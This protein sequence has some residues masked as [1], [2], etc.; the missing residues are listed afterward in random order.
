MARDLRRERTTFIL[1]TK[2]RD[3]EKLCGGP[4]L[5]V[6]AWLC[7]HVRRTCR[8]FPELQSA[9]GTQKRATMELQ[10]DCGR[11]RAEIRLLAQGAA[12]KSCSICWGVCCCAAPLLNSV[13]S[14]FQWSAC[15]CQQCAGSLAAL[16]RRNCGA[17]LLN[18]TLHCCIHLL[19]PAQHSSRHR[20]TCQ[21]LRL[22][23]LHACGDEAVG[24]AQSLRSNGCSAKLLRSA[25]AVVLCVELNTFEKQ[26]ADSSQVGRRH[27]QCCRAAESAVSHA[28]P[29][30]CGGRVHAASPK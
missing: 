21:R 1:G 22:R 9:F 6:N 11:R 7:K 25:R 5:V 14:F 23:T 4:L 10:R 29:C 27:D 20:V 3:E 17:Q 13:P 19:G 12:A 8:K 15:P 2:L 30:A 24:A 28:G 26:R 16:Q 18:R